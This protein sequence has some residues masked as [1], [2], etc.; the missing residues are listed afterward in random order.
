MTLDEAK[1]RVRVL[2]EQPISE[3]CTALVMMAGNGAQY[4]ARYRAR[5]KLLAQLGPALVDA[6][7]LAEWNENDSSA[8]EA[9]VE[10]LK[11]DWLT[12][13]SSDGVDPVPRAIDAHRIENEE[14]HAGTHATAEAAHDPTDRGIRRPKAGASGRGK[15]DDGIDR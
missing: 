3:G 7:R 11:L 10:Q 8:I 13:V 6:G 14:H 2:V 9:A 15:A 12:T 5:Q 1:A 4:A